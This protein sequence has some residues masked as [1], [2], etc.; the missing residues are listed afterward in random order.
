MRVR[1]LLIFLMMAVFFLACPRQAVAYGR[2]GASDLMYIPTSGTLNQ[3]VY[4][5]YLTF[6]S[7]GAVL[8]GDLGLIPNLELGAVVFIYEGQEDASLRDK[9]HLLQEKRDGF[10]LAVGIEDI[11]D[12]VISPYLVAGKTLTPGLQGYLGFGGGEIAGIFFGLN[13]SFSGRQE[14]SIFVEYDSSHLNLGARLK[15]QAN[16]G[17]D[18]GI[19]DLETLVVGLSYLGTF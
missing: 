19:I 15:L 7:G 4:G 1:R 11:G 16:L 6:S 10:G 5:L 3:D 14:G 2:F 12:G 13:K 17:L 8:G 9:Y 18:V